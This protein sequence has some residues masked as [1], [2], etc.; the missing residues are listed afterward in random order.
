MCVRLVFV[1]QASLRWHCCHLWPP[2]VHLRWR[3]LALP[4][5]RSS[6]FSRTSKPSKSWPAKSASAARASLSI[7]SGGNSPGLAPEFGA[8]TNREQTSGRQLRP[9]LLEAFLSDP[10]LVVVTA[11]G[12]WGAGHVQQGYRHN[13]LCTERGLLHLCFDMPWPFALALI[14][15]HQDLALKPTE[16]CMRPM[17]V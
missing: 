7:R 10:L 1:R 11:H 5:H 6:R 14:S 3:Q 17:R 16:R 2:F 8:G 4:S 12:L 15:H 9:P 13:P